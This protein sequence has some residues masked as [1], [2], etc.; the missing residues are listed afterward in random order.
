MVFAAFVKIS[1]RQSFESFANWRDATLARME[2]SAT[3]ICDVPVEACVMIFP[4]RQ[5][6]PVEREYVAKSQSAFF[7]CP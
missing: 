3:G 1:F 6:Y 5:C 4:S 7:L 2:S